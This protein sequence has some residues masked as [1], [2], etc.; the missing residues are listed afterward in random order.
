MTI[1][2]QLC[3]K[4]NHKSKNTGGF[5]NKIKDINAIPENVT[6]CCADVVDLYPSIPHQAGRSHFRETLDESKIDKVPA[7]KLGN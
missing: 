7:G 2:P 4:G 1:L 3:G 5:L 6:L